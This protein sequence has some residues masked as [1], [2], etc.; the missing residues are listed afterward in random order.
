MDITAL[1]AIVPAQISFGTTMKYIAIFAAAV[2]AA[3]LLFRIFLGRR[4]ALN[5]AI[6]AGIGVLCVYVLTIIIYTFS[7]GNL[8]RFLVPLPFM[9]FSG[10]TVQIAGFSSA[11]F[12][13]LCA[14]FL[15]LVMLVL[16]Y[17]LSD[18]LLP[19]GET[20][21]TWLLFRSIT[22]L[23]A[24]AVHYFFTLLTHEFL[25]ALLVSYGP[26]ILLILLVISLLAGLVGA[27]LGFLLVVVNPILGFLF[28]FF[29]ASG[30]G[31]Q[32]SKAMLTTGILT[33]LAVTL[34]H[35]GYGV[36][37][38]TAASLLSYIPL[39]LILIAIWWILE[40]VF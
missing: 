19:D 27:L 21:V 31:K 35:L 16:L 5:R 2:I 7:P 29:F 28:H 14:D 15:S 33:G 20:A 4:S 17:N 6:C 39:L 37:S 8:E 36:V 40:R 23:M 3:G 1:T 34:N 11:D 13:T 24:M 32:I 9:Q 38:I 22:I 12:P 30:L 26:T 25:P 18:N 10:H